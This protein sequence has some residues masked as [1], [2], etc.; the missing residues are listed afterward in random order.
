[1][2]RKSGSNNNA[3]QIVSEDD[4]A[5]LAYQRGTAREREE[6][7]ISLKARCEELVAICKW[8]KPTT[9]KFFTDLCL[10]GHSCPTTDDPTYRGPYKIPGTGAEAQRRKTWL[11]AVKLLMGEASEDYVAD[12]GWA[13]YLPLVKPWAVNG[14]TVRFDWKAFYDTAPLKG[15]VMVTLDNVIR[16]DQTAVAAVLKKGFHGAVSLEAMGDRIAKI[17]QIN[18]ENLKMCIDY[19]SV[20]GKTTTKVATLVSPQLR[21][22]GIALLFKR[23]PQESGYKRIF[24]P[25]D[26]GKPIEGITIE[27]NPKLAN[28]VCCFFNPHHL[29][30]TKECQAS[31]RDDTLMKKY[32][33]IYV[34]LL[35]KIFEAFGAEL[36]WTL[37]GEITGFFADTNKGT[38]DDV[39]A[40]QM[41]TSDL[42]YLW[43]RY[44][45][46]NVGVNRVK[47]PKAAKE[48]NNESFGGFRKVKVDSV[49]FNF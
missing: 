43:A 49:N 19:V 14:K 45:N 6:N 8:D 2:S 42:Q 12:S 34:K 30:F 47:D 29:V 22:K 10:A 28:L 46:G 9:G 32:V 25:T 13:K 31:Q 39:A 24:L 35:T 20:E 21:L 48:R 40:L 1:M 33:A 18:W 41:M 44:R 16:G 3:M 15:W 23:V 17:I 4:I 27:P 26:S 38:D 11:A 7:Q 36:G 37:V 5:K